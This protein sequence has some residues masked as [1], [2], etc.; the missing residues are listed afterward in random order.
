MSNLEEL[1]CCVDDFCQKFIPFWHQQLIE[2]GLLSKSSVETHDEVHER[3]AQSTTLSGDR[4]TV[5][6]G[7]NLNIIGSNVAGTQ[8]V[9]LA[10]GNQLNLH[11]SDV[12]AGRDTQLSGQN[13]NITSA[14]NSHTAVTK[15]EQKQSGLTVALSGTA[16][17]ALNSAVQTVQAAN[18]ESDS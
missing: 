2:N 1:D 16:G 12:V 15:T 5:Q 4:M 18:N 6:T 8:D 10:A 14:E 11:G 7:N 9:N 17:G 3:R 13:I